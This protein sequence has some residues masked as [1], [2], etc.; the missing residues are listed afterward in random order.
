[1][2]VLKVLAIGL[3]EWLSTA[4]GSTAVAV[5]EFG[6]QVVYTVFEGLLRGNFVGLRQ[7]VR[8]PR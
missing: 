7:F 1:M 2:Q 3:T 6:R 5:A 8:F 4:E